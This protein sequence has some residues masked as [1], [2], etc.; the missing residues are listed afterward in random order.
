MASDASAGRREGCV[1][2]KI[3]DLF[4]PDEPTPAIRKW[5]MDQQLGLAEC[6]DVAFRIVEMM[7]VV[8]AIRYLETRLSAGHVASLILGA[9]IPIYVRGKVAAA[10]YPVADRYRWSER[11]RQWVFWACVA[12][13]AG[14]WVG[15]FVIVERVVPLLEAKG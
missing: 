1:K 2:L 14:A 4:R 8:G 9:L 15:S 6:A 11:T 12:I 13:A 3:R 5:H 10:F 7:L